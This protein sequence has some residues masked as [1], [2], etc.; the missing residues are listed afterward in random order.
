MNRQTMDQF[1]I[2]APAFEGRS[3]QVSAGA[4]FAWLRMGWSVFMVNPGVW[5][6]SAVIV[7]VG[8]LALMSVWLVGVLLASL[9][10]PLVAAG[11]LTMS[12]R[13]ADGTEPALSD[14]GAGF[15]TRTTPLLVLGVIFLIA[16]VAINVLV[17][18]MIGGSL[19]GGLMM[20]GAA[21][22]SILLGGSLLALLF[23]SVLLIPLGMALWFAPMLVLF[24]GMPPIE[25]C[26]AS[27]N[28]CLKN[29]LPFLLFSLI[30]FVLSFFAALPVGL[31][32]LVLIPVL[33]GTAYAAYQDVFVA[34]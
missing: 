16:N 9:L 30:V 11:L 19:A 8:F 22:A 25:A 17:F 13:A 7:L 27:F 2:Q 18:L 24:N 23:S 6:V 26:K 21:G 5:A 14:L 31:G 28:A 12:R 4:V 33:A 20:Q 34:Y 15:N 29:I 32:F 1:P 10:A 3:R